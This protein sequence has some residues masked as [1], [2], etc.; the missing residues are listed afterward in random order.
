MMRAAAAGVMTGLLLTWSMPPGGTAALAWIALVPVAF[1]WQRGATGQAALAGGVAGTL[2]AWLPT[3][4]LADTFAAHTSLGLGGAVLGHLGI[5]MYLG[6]FV[7]A[8]AAA[9]ALWRRATGR[10]GIVLAPILWIGTEWVRGMHPLGFPWAHLGTSQ[11]DVPPVAQLA[12]VGGVYAVSGLLVLVNVALA[13]VVSRRWPVWRLSAVLALVFGAVM[14][15]QA[16][17]AR[18]EEQATD[19]LAVGIVQTNVP[20]GVRWHPRHRDRA[21]DFLAVPTRR[22]AAQGADVVIWPETALPFAFEE[23]PR[24]RRALVALV[25][26]IGVPIVFGSTADERPTPSERAR[27][28]RI[29]LVMPNGEI[30]GHYDKQVLVPIGEYVPFARWLSWLRPMIAGGG[31]ITPGRPTPL[32]D[33]GGVRAGVLVCYEAI[34]PWVAAAHAAH[35]AQVLLNLSN[36]GWYAGSAAPWQLLAEA[37]IRAIE[38]GAPLV[39]VANGGPSAVVSATGRLAWVGPASG[40][41]ATVVPVRV[42]SDMPPE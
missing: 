4:W 38:Q 30:A 32:L 26:E 22:L 10:S 24:G 5:A 1:V 41:A 14:W 42:R 28:N 37:R 39:R 33:V 36:D 23:D 17:L 11:V 19:L 29:Y 9:M 8:V 3:R 20:Q 2:G 15:G 7:A 25:R 34:V 40:S 27:R 21:L 18:L 16:R 31:P 13:L 6:C 12:S 35:G